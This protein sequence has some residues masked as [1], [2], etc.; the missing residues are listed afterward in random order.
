[1]L[2]FATWA[3]VLN[4][5]SVVYEGDPAGAGKAVESLMA[6]R[7]EA[8]A[9]GAAEAVEAD[10]MAEAAANRRIAGTVSRRTMAQEPARRRPSGT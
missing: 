6:R 7:E 10:D 2:E 9:T 3:V 8:A 5:G 1:M 4:H